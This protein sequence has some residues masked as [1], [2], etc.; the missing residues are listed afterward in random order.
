MWWSAQTWC[1]SR[2]FGLI[3]TSHRAARAPLF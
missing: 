2:N 1:S 3:L